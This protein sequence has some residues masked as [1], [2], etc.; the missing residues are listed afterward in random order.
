MP[1]DLHHGGRQ[2]LHLR[3]QR[4]WPAGARRQDEQREPHAGEDT[5]KRPSD[6]GRCGQVS[7]ALSYERWRS[8]GMR[9][10]QVWRAWPGIV[11]LLMS[12]TNVFSYW[13]VLLLEQVWRAWQGI[14]LVLCVLLLT[15]S[16]TIVF[17][18]SNTYGELDQVLFSY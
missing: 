16:L 13:C 3:P 8:V 6:Q 9:V 10:Q 5:G 1:H 14:V 2:V 4:A 11:L 12:L 15:C 17:P 18:Y 7:H